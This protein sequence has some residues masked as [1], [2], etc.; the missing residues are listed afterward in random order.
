MG[1]RL[2]DDEARQ[3]QDERAVAPQTDPQR[4]SHREQADD[5]GRHEYQEL[6]VQ[7]HQPI[8]VRTA[9]EIVKTLQHVRTL[10]ER[11][12]ARSPN[13]LR[14]IDVSRL[15]EREAPVFQ[16]AVFD[17]DLHHTVEAIVVRRDLGVRPAVNGLEEE[18]QDDRTEGK[19]Q[20]GSETHV[21]CGRHVGGESGSAGKR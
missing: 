11:H 13:L 3:S 21:A 4:Q 16:I 6:V 10:Q 1:E 7:Q 9:H 17:P 15:G 8:A 2:K 5:D 12:R 19:V 14:R 18:D 20:H